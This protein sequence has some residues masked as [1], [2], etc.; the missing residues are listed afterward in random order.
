MKTRDG[1]L[2]VHRAPDVVVT[3]SGAAPTESPALPSRVLAVAVVAVLALAL[4]AT[5]GLMWF[6]AGDHGVSTRTPVQPGAAGPARS[7]A[8]EVEVSA[9]AEVT[10]GVAAT[11]TITWRDGDG[12]FS[13][14][15]EEWG[16]GVGVSSEQQARCDVTGPRADRPGR[17][18]IEVPHVFAKPGRYTVVLGVTT[19][20]CQGAAAT[21]ESAAETLTVTVQQAR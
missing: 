18:S 10:A 16:D 7:E 6:G 11:F 20:T 19:Y 5:L 15:T 9:P 21:T 2:E 4:L 1:R 8:L 14:T 12:I 17:G 13:G 3:G